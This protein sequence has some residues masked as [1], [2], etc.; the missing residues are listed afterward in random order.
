VNPDPCHEIDRI[1]QDALGRKQAERARFLDEACVNDASLRQE[2][3]ALIAA[4]EDAGSVIASPTAR[5]A[6]D[7]NDSLVG[8]T[9]ANYRVESLIG[10]GGM[11]EVYR[12]YD[13][14]LQRYVAIK[15]LP[16][17]FARDRERLARFRREAQVLASLDYVSY[18]TPVNEVW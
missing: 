4:H 1:F 18:C 3:E 5:A 9:I 17:A 8:R 16:K 12:A 11:G 7:N 6:S 2:V 13:C 15:V 14:Q 10:A